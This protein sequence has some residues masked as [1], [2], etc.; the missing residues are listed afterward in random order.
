M[1]AVPDEAAGRPGC[2]LLEKLLIFDT[3]IFEKEVAAVLPHLPHLTFLGYKVRYLPVPYL[4]AVLWIRI[5]PDPKLFA[6]SGIINFGS[7]SS[8]LQF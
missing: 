8:N 7:G 4:L 2:V 6:G 1:H 5:R 3:G